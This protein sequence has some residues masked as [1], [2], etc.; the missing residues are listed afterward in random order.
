MGFSA[1]FLEITAAL[2]GVGWAGIF[3]PAWSSFGITTGGQLGE[4]GLGGDDCVGTGPGRVKVQW[5]REC[6]Q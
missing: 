4:C 5:T 3:M 2:G 1:A 6:C